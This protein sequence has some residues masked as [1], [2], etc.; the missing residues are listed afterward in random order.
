MLLT[1]SVTKILSGTRK[2][3]TGFLVV[4]MATLLL[5]ACGGEDSV[6]LE[7][8]MQ[9]ALDWQSD[10]DLKAAVIE[11]KNALVTYPD[12]QDARILLGRVY[13][14]LGMGAAAEK[15]ISKAEELGIDENTI[16]LPLAES[17]LLQSKLDEI[18]E[19]LVYEPDSVTAVSLG[20]RYFLGE[21]YLGKGQIKKAEGYFDEVLQATPGNMKAL[22]GKARISFIKKD[23]EN[24]DKYIA[25]AAAILPNNQELLQL[26]AS[27]SW[28]SGDF[29]AV[30][31]YYRKLV[32]YYPS[33]SINEVYLAWV[34]LIN[35]KTDEAGPRLVKLRDMAPENS[36]VNFVSAL[37]AV[38]GKNYPDAK[39][40]VEKVLSR[41]PGDYRTK[42]IGATATYALGEY[43]QSYAYI[44]QYLQVI[45]DD[46]RAKELL[47]QLQIRLK[48]GTEAYAT[49][50]DLSVQAEKKEKFLNMLAKYELQKG[51]IEQ[52]RVHLEQSLLENPDQIESRQNL[53]YLR[54]AK[55]DIDEGMAEMERA[56]SEIPD[57]FKRQMQRA[58]MLIIVKKYDEAI[59]ICRDL[60]KMDPDNVNGFICE[61]TAYYKK[62]DTGEALSP[63]LKVLAKKPGNKVASRLVASIHLKNKS[64]EKARNVQGKYLKIHPVDAKSTFGMYLL[65]MKA[66]KEK[67]AIGYLKK[68]VELNPNA[69]MPVLVLARH[70]LTEEQP[71]K[72]LEVSDSIMPLFPRAEGLLEVRGKA[73]MSL[74]RFDAAAR[75]FEKLV[76]ENPE[77]VLA[78]QLLASAYDANRDYLKLDITAREILSLKP[79]DVKAR[80][81]SAKVGASRGKWQEADD[82][83]SNIKG[84]FTES[85]EYYSLRGRVNLAK[86]NFDQAIYYFDKN[87][88]ANPTIATAIQL[89]MVNQGAGKIDAALEVMVDWHQKNP[90]DTLAMAS[91][92]DLYLAKGAYGKANENYRRILE[93]YPASD[94]I[95]NNLAWSLLKLGKEDEALSTIHKARKENPD[96]ADF[97]DTEAEILLAK[98]EVKGAIRQY[99][100]AAAKAPDDLKFK[101]HLALALN[102]AGQKEEAIT[103]LKDLKADGRP[104]EGQN[105][106]FDLLDQLQA[107]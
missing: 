100:K 51:D 97:I 56:L 37:H 68:S 67:E 66:D 41:V 3:V 93:K 92:G 48:K 53:A 98:G 39:A 40:Y 38:M 64:Y 91:L 9:R 59:K 80:I 94:N 79:D 26:K 104:F 34:E 82:I 35:G 70:Y 24:T 23:T 61:G 89:A 15:E 7:D 76:K 11:L 65:L 85:P 28:L 43:E 36:L 106:A 14:E 27:R 90:D 13:L 20:K 6:S 31:G 49:L 17:W 74:K 78:L 29:E 107:E 47:V 46:E 86:R 58:R 87:Y 99:R 32:E 54:I 21:A 25:L 8:R 62:G 95:L 52:A 102:K 16:I 2:T 72:A 103:T 30:E 77:N 22:V 60:Q 88:K 83:L 96:S 81:Y 69:R 101:Y 4:I 105:E 75:S 42:F 50:K 44:K 18:I 33:Y 73:Q 19:R 57:E 45:P 5:S 55:G 1:Q 63:L 71:E 10:G 84:A 12:S